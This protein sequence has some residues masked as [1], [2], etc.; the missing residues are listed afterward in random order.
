M[1]YLFWKFNL[2]MQTANMRAKKAANMTKIAAVGPMKFKLYPKW[3]STYHLMLGSGTIPGT[4]I[5]SSM[6][7]YC[8][9]INP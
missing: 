9:T 5:V 7:P 3:F 4:L 6:S 1:S 8:V 2:L